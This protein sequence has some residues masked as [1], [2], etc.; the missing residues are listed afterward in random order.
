[1]PPLLAG[2]PLPGRALPTSMR[3]D[4]GRHPEKAYWARTLLP[5]GPPACGPTSPWLRRRL[6][7]PAGSLQAA[8]QGTPPRIACARLSYMWHQ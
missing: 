1:V 5:F 3:L 4:N 8:R 2:A 6:A 7:P